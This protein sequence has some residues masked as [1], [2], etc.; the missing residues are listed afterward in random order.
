MG[1]SGNVFESLPAR[2]GP[3][4]SSL[5]KFTEFGIIF[6]RN[7]TRYFRR[8]CRTWKLSETR[9]CRVRQYQPHVFNQGIANFE[10]IK[11]Y[12]RNLFSAMVW[13]I[14]R[15]FRSRKCIF[16]TSQTHWNFKAGKSTS[17]LKYV[18]NQRFLT[19]RCTGSKKLRWQSQ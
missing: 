5:R 8:Y 18:R 10:P 13:S 9:A 2:E 4:F 3:S 1:T 12:W 17:R 7:G 6:L 16:E 15:D 11:S 19:S 14:T